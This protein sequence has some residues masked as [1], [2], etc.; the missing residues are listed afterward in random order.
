MISWVESQRRLNDGVFIRVS[1]VKDMPDW[2]YVSI[3]AA[4]G[5]SMYMG[6]MR[7]IEALCEIPYQL[8]RARDYEREYAE[9]QATNNTEGMGSSYSSLTGRPAGGVRDD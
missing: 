6:A 1:E 8:D 9:S 7:I 5:P 4:N 3:T 2:V